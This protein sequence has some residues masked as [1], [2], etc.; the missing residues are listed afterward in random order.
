MPLPPP[1][2]TNDQKVQA[3]PKHEEYESRKALE[4]SQKD[5]LSKASAEVEQL[6]KE[7][8]NLKAKRMEAESS[9]QRLKSNST[10]L[11]KKITI[12]SSMRMRRCASAKM[13]LKLLSSEL[14]IAPLRP[15]LPE[16]PK[17]VSGSN[18]NQ[19]PKGIVSWP[20]SALL[21]RLEPPCLPCYPRVSLPRTPTGPPHVLYPARSTS[22]ANGV[23]T[24]DTLQRVK[25]PRLALALLQAE[26]ERLAALESAAHSSM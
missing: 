11:S 5:Q 22:I 15:M 14:T 25:D 20:A 21:R 24:G 3:Q 23:I 12:C 16:K 19:L 6:I 10:E 26:K 17:P 4:A 1:A 2:P 13:L 9:L 18:S 7:E 8:L